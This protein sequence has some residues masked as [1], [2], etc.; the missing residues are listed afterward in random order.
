VNK[1]LNISYDILSKVYL[2]GSYVSI[3]L[4]KFLN[5]PEKFNSALV[6]KIVYGVLEKD[7]LLEYFIGQSVKKLPEPKILILLKIVAYTSKAINS[8]PAFALV[9]EVVSIAKK[10]DF[11]KSGFVNAV[12][13]KLVSNQIVL[14]NKKD[15]TKYLSVKYNFPEWV[16]KELLK[17][18]D[19]QFVTELVSCELINLTHIRVNLDKISVNDFVKKLQ[20]HDV[21]FKQSFYDYT[22]Y[23][24]YAKLLKIED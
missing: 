18:H 17:E 3:E 12:S 11:H 14:P 19:T 20:E 9:N 4:N 15:I 13:K 24:D 1:E 10:V 7:I 5:K 22:F 21:D 16:I 6:T 23:V 8:I 2:D